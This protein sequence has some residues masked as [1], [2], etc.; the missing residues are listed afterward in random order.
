MIPQV[1]P[2]QRCFPDIRAPTPP[3][4]WV[5]SPLTDFLIRITPVVQGRIP[6]L[7][8]F[9]TTAFAPPGPLARPPPPTGHTM[10][11]PMPHGGK[12]PWPFGWC[13][14]T[15]VCFFDFSF[16]VVFFSIP[17]SPCGYLDIRAHTPAR[18]NRPLMGICSRKKNTEHNP[19][20]PALSNPSNRILS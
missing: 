5:P 4:S 18:E 3:S 6:P 17:T 8:L 2:H 13:T 10:F 15:R 11:L 9:D 1:P 7:A 20:F 16:V 12:T 14:F 19:L